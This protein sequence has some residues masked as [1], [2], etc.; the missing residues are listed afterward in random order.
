MDNNKCDNTIIASSFS[1][2]ELE[3]MM[4]TWFD[5]YKANGESHYNDTQDFRIR[6]IYWD[7]VVDKVIEDVN[8][9]MTDKEIEMFC[10]RLSTL[11]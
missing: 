9:E 4:N 7:K 11:G 10:D 8:I 5:H 3:N 1:D 2:L 6:E